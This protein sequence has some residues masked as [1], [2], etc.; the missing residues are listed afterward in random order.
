MP[1]ASGAAVDNLEPG[2]ETLK[3]GGLKLQPWA[4]PVSAEKTV[5]VGKPVSVLYALLTADLPADQRKAFLDEFK[6]KDSWQGVPI[7]QLVLKYADGTA[8]TL[9][10]LYGYHVRAVTP[11]EPFP[12]AFGAMATTVLGEPKQVAYLAPLNNPNPD[13]AVAEVR[14]VPGSL[15]AKPALRALAVRN[16]WQAQ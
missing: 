3:L 4:T 8:A 13:K 12:Q 14:F 11:E 9:P 7:G 10:L 6:K 15:G 5:A 16:V 1:P 2:P